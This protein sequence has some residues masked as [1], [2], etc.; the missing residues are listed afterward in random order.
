MGII[1]G[2]TLRAG[3]DNKEYREF[4]NQLEARAFRARASEGETGDTLPV[5]MIQ[6]GIG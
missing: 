5:W 1:H 4:L 6:L 3:S 2:E